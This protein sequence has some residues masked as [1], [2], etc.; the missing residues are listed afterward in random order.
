MTT[1]EVLIYLSVALAL[2]EAL[3]MIPGLKSN[4]ILQL[5]INV[6]KAIVPKK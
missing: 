4:S 3:G 2:S 6:L 1:N 5:V